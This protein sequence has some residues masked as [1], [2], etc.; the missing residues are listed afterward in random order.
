MILSNRQNAP[1]VISSLLTLLHL[2]IATA[3]LCTQKALC[4]RSFELFD[5]VDAADADVDAIHGIS[6][7]IY[8]NSR[9]I[10]SAVVR[11]FI[12]IGEALNNFSR[13]EPECTNRRRSSASAA[14]PPAKRQPDG[15]LFP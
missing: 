12:Y 6:L 7:D 4:C 2:F 8:C 9:L 1:T 5:L 3:C 15:P 13:L 10:R 14:G 11:E